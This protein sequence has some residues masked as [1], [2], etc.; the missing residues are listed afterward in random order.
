MLRD[1]FIGVYTNDQ[2]MAQSLGLSQGIR[3]AE[4]YHVE[5]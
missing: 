1:F 5:T 4:M 2:V 3:M